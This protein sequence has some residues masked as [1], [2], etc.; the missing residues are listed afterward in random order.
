MFYKD[1]HTMR[2][3][4]IFRSIQGEST[5]AG[6]PCTFIRTAGCSLRCKYCDTQYAWDRFSGEDLSLDEILHS[7][8]TLGIDLVEITGGEPLEEPETP[9]LCRHLLEQG[10]AVLVETS[11]AYPISVLPK[12][13][14]AILDVK[15]PSSTMEKRNH[16]ENLEKLSEKDE[17]K[18]V[19]SN[20][21]DFDWSTGIC[22]KYKLYGRCPVLFSPA[23]SLLEPQTLAKWILDEHIPVR[24]QIQIH[25]VIWP[26]DT[27]GV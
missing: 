20:R 25:K 16:W 5:Y 13:T 12:G 26:H 14:I 22:H 2:I 10:S 21:E 27:R 4:E 15:T 3:S 8:K 9:E 24:L 23:F 7:T 19:I 17:L 18:F 6:L 11:G 1:L